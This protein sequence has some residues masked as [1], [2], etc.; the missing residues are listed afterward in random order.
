MPKLIFDPQSIPVESIAGE[1]PV[2]PEQLA[3]DC[4]RARFANP[5]V[6]TPEM[7]DEHRARNALVLPKPASVLI[8][9]VLRENGLTLLFT[10]RT[11]HL[12]D[13]AGQISFPG[14]RAE[15]TDTSRIEDRKSVV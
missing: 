11:A 3:P 6:W 13:H 7:T 9:I 5:P 1:M 15:D 12:T 2:K 4:L 14:G 10:Q 8:P